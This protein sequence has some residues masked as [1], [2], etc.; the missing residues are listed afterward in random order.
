MRS[1]Y[2]MLSISVVVAPILAACSADLD[3]DSDSEQSV[4]DNQSS[5]LFG[6]GG[7]GLNESV[8]DLLC[9]LDVRRCTVHATVVATGIPG[10]G[11]VLQV[12]NFLRSSPIHDR[13]VFASYIAPGGVLN[14][15]RVLVGSSSNFGAPLGNTSEYEG[16]VLSIDPQGAGPVTVPPTFAA[17]GGQAS[18]LGG[19]VEV[20][21]AN[22]AAFFQG[23]HNPTALNSTETG[24]SLPTG[25]S[26]NNGNGRPWVANSPHGGSAAGTIAV[27]DPDGPTLNGPP[28]PAFGGIFT[29]AS[30]N[31]GPNSG[32]GLSTGTLGTAII[33]KSSDGSG[34]A[35]FAALNADGSI[36]QVHV[37]KGV[38]AL[39]PAGSI[40]PNYDITPA[41][42]ESNDRRTV[43]RAGMAFNWAPNETLYVVDPKKNRLVAF[44][45]T[46]D[47]TLFHAAA[48]RYLLADKLDIPVD[49][50]PTVPE[51]A[52]SNFS[53]NSTLAAG[54]DL[55]ILNRGDNS[56]VRVTQEGDIVA[57]RNLVVDG[58]PGFRAN[59]LG[60]SPDG[61]TIYVTGQEGHRGGLVVKIDGFGSGAI[62]P[63]LMS[64]AGSS[65][66]PSTLGGFF[67]NHDFKLLEGVGPLYNAQGCA[68]CHND[69]IP[70][71]MG[72]S[73][74][75]VAI[76]GSRHDPVARQHSINEIGG[77]CGLRPGIPHG[78][79]LTSPRSTMALRS[80][81]LI[82]FV[83][84]TQIRANQALEPEAI[85]GRPNILADGRI[86]KFG[87]KAQTATLIEFMGQAFRNE[88]GLTNGLDRKDLVSGCGANLVRPE[89]DAVPLVTTASFLETIDAPAPAAECRT[90]A[91]A[92]VFN[93]TGCSGCH[94]ESFSG[95]GFPAYLYSDLLLHDMGPTLAD[96]FPQG[97]ATG[98]EFRT[99]TLV[100]LNER[101]HFLHD[102]RALT[103]TDAIRAHGGQAATSEA[104]FEG[105]STAD[106][107]ALL[108]FLGCL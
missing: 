73:V 72:D 43:V 94:T 32:A 90:S 10:A 5:A 80:T 55:Y 102:G 47:G 15:E 108:A 87:W 7:D 89:L 59:G 39:A 49:V 45:I 58:H 67:F 28:N 4:A 79:D 69:P 42:A 23:V 97:S 76:S 100:K 6:L 98:S 48:P 17:A 85:R 68:G 75:D 54:A 29:G 14:R 74:L 19:L 40:T 105:L 53:S 41:N 81:S 63:G 50:A 26:I 3:S 8:Q 56:I 64:Q 65:S 95:P 99:M 84:D 20:Y 38:D 78:T 57:R 37:Q 91:G 66:Q 31:R 18:A 13:P 52:S 1:K 86:G 35:V 61:R 60:V 27:L 24:A 25:L 33:T 104:A 92:T 21:T 51:V 16:T 103:P 36:V 44:D 70:G 83:L 2:G 82:D 88:Q 11:P 93:T 77:I 107:D 9:R 34:R 96:G 12:S 101:K 30:T 71:G 46:A 106:R 62:M 22:N